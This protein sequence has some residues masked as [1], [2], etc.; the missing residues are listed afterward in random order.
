[1]S[2]GVFLSA[3]GHESHKLQ[4]YVDADY[5]YLASNVSASLSKL[6]VSRGSQV[7][8][9]QLLA[10]LEAQPEKSRLQGAQAK[11]D[12][13]FEQLK[14]H[15]TEL[16]YQTGLFNRYQ[17]LLK[18]GS[19]SQEE[20]D[21]VQRNYLSARTALDISEATLQATLANL[22]Q[23]WWDQS[24]KSLLAPV[25]GYVYDV[26]YTVGEL[27]P[28]AHPVLA[29]LAP[30]NLKITFFVPET[31]LSSLRLNQKVKVTCDGCQKSIFAKIVYI[32][33]QSEYTLPFIYSE[34]T[35]T[36]FSYRVEAKPMD[37]VS[38]LHPGQPVSIDLH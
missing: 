35:R 23:A 27:V 30:K 37:S 22:T 19:V 11:S 14:Q 20:F 3:C 17:E 28:A 15:R 4:G 1:M 16:N 32:S 24:N 38:K 12:E 5:T 6:L 36:K 34:E 26:Y 9:G 25:S 18:A 33:S 8:E 31:L 10:M 13:A 7:N 29:L 2:T 21:I